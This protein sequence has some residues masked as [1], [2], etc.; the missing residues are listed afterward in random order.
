MKIVLVNHYAGSPSHGME[1]RPHQFA[2]RWVA[3]G[4]DVTILAGSFSHLRNRNPEFQ[5]RSQTE[6]IDGIRY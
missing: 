5:G 2:R 1:F 6:W 4:H 3:W